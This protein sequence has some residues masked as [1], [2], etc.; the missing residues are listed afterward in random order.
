VGAPLVESGASRCGLTGVSGPADEEV[1]QSVTASVMQL[2]PELV[3]GTIGPLQRNVYSFV[4]SVTSPGGAHPGVFVKI[5]KADLRRSSPHILPLTESDRDLGRTEHESLCHLGQRW[6]GARERVQFVQP[7]AYLQDWNAVVTI[8]APA[9]E[10]VDALRQ[11]AWRERLG[12]SSDATAMLRRLAAALRRFHDTAATPSTL[13]PAEVVRKV[14]RY[15][16]ALS[17]WAVAPEYC[18]RLLSMIEQRV[19]RAPLPVVETTTLKGIDVRNV[20]VDPAGRL[21][22][23]DP[24]RMKRAPREADLAR[25]LITWRILY[26][27]R[28]VFA[29]GAVPPARSEAEFL[30][31]YGGCDTRVLRMLIVKELFKHWHT[32]HDSLRLKPWSTAR[33]RIVA[34]AYIDRF[35]RRQLLAS[36]EGLDA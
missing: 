4:F 19:G 27:G 35:Y 18:A 9:A 32:A 26:W 8:R 22:L 15:V 13:D 11:A 28:P 23:V 24:G 2:V 14:R 31:A 25:F 21:Y 36:V 20:L 17:E 5:P 33:R 6:D 1:Q 3:G 29:F 30:A 10:A 34:A 7:V 16:I 12:V